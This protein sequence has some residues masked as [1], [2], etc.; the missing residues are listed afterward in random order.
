MHYLQAGEVSAVAGM[1]SQIEWGLRENPGRFDIDDDGLQP[2]ARLQWD[3][4][5]AVKH[6]HRQLAYAIEAVL[7]EAVRDG[8]MERLFADQGVSYLT[9][10]LYL[11]VDE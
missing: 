6:T 11:D 9:P 2:I 4:G 5:A 7:D 1:R 10:A 3:I 8:R